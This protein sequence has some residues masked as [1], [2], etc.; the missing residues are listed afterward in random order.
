ME[1]YIYIDGEKIYVSEEVYRAYKRPIW[2]EQKCRKVRREKE[3]ALDE[4]LGT[5][6]NAALVDEI[7]A[8]KLLLELL[9]EALDTQL[10]AEERKLVDRLYF[11]DK[12]ER[13]TA[14]ETGR[15]KTSVHKQKVR[16][17]EKLQKKFDLG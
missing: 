17:I 4:T 5:P 6:S 3:Q 14:K 2:R 15:S 16:I 7:V 12:S 9:M 10:T 11:D 8:D 13:E 1:R